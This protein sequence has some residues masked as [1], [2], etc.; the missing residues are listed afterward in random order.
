WGAE[1][2]GDASGKS[3]GRGDQK[4]GT[5]ESK[6][7]SKASAETGSAK[8]S[9][10]AKEKEKWAASYNGGWGTMSPS[11][12]GGWGASTSWGT[13][14]GADADGDATMQDQDAGKEE[15]EVQ[16]GADATMQDVPAEEANED[17][18]EDHAWLQPPQTW[19]E[20]SSG[21][22]DA[23]V[24]ANMGAQAPTRAGIQEPD[25]SR[26]S[27][28]DRGASAHIPPITV[29]TPAMDVDRKQR[30]PSAT[31]FDSDVGRYAPESLP[32][33]RD[34]CK[35]Q[36]KSMAH[37]VQ[38]YMRLQKEEEELAKYKRMQISKSY[39]RVGRSGQDILNA[40][41]KVF[42]DKVTASRKEYD[43]YINK[44]V[45]YPSLESILMGFDPD[46]EMR[47]ALDYLGQIKEWTA[48]VQPSVQHIVDQEAKA[49]E[50]KRQRS[51]DEPDYIPASIRPVYQQLRN[52][53]EQTAA[54]QAELEY[55]VDQTPDLAQLAAQDEALREPFDAL[56]QRLGAVGAGIEE[57]ANRFA[58][59]MNIEAA[60]DIGQ[61]KAEH[62]DLK[63][64]VSQIEART[65]QTHAEM[66]SRWPRMSAEEREALAVDYRAESERLERYDLNDA[67]ERA[68][69]LVLE[70]FMWGQ[71]S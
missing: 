52:L 10:K 34:A 5:S 38:L 58:P 19:T 35:N 26:K 27:Q 47:S 17:E 51:P 18:D 28:A 3:T 45:G 56:N 66:A 53:E 33:R 50:Q 67:F 61:I 14:G 22:G 25:P 30:E 4:T 32:G 63:A 9:E 36:I 20:I 23:P 68:K 1:G 49:Q 15:G 8:T 41:R 16:E 69:E 54:M 37:A 55:R 44:L 64:Q 71:G 57:Q 31:P 40:K 43:M 70:Q 7:E 46:M 29:P 12:G 42:Q 2:G 60:Q 21:L 65:A 59:L 24:D 62:E 11:S 6:P 13:E 39:E 48:A